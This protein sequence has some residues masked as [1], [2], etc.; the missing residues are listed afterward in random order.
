MMDAFT[1]NEPTRLV[2]GSGS[3]SQ[4][5]QELSALGARRAFI[6]TGAGP[7]SSSPGLARVRASLEAAGV[8]SV[9]YA[10]VGHVGDE[11]NSRSVLGADRGAQARD[12]EASL[13]LGAD[14]RELGF[15]EVARLE[16]AETELGGRSEALA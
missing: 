4:A 8:E 11:E 9:V 12:R 1:W 14:A 5:G 16:L 6:V 13:D 7:T 3:A 15:E 10:R 2:F